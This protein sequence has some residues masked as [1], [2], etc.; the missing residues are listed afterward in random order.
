MLSARR[1]STASSGDR[2]AAGIGR[3]APPAASSVNS[4]PGAV[5]RLERRARRPSARRARGR[6]P[7]RARSRPA[8]RSRGRAGS[9]RRSARAPRA[10]RPGPRRGRSATRR[11][12]L[13]S[14]TVI[15][16]PSGLTRTALSSRIR[17]IRATLPGIAERPHRAGRVVERRR[18]SRARRC[19]SSNSASTARLSSPSSTGSERSW[20]WASSRL[21]SSRSAAS[22]ASR[23]DW[24]RARSSSERASSR[25]GSPPCRSSSSSSSIPSS[26][27]SGV[28]SSCEAVATN[29]RRASSC[30]W[31]RLLHQ[32]ERPGQVADL[33]ARAVGR[34]LD[35]RPVL[36]E[37]Q[38]GLAQAAQ[39]ADDRAGSGIA[40]ISV[41]A[42]PASAAVRNAV[43]TA[44][45]AL[46]ISSIGLRTT[47]TKRL[48][49]TGSAA[50]AYVGAADRAEAD[51][52]PCRCGTPRSRRR[53][54][55]PVP[56]AASL[57]HDRSGSRARRH[58]GSRA[59]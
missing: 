24:A 4:R 40:R 21:R 11:A 41:S 29:A 10:A 12:P 27:A 39:P 22:R 26:E 23:R 30:C 6:S 43:R 15:S 53:T 35:G 16:A 56:I 52:W 54:R 46:G 14:S 20:T 58:P 38:R 36:G 48:V 9:A 59:A 2:A 37:P 5:A 50:R 55:L 17:R 32:R 25:S 47:S 8:R 28:R 13:R 1:L 49:L 34:D 3:A 18:R 31:R 33:V 51:I 42:S 7:A 57:A 19:P 45:T 44:W